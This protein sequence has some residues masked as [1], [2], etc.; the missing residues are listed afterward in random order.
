MLERIINGT[1]L[2]ESISY[3]GGEQ[4][5]TYSGKKGRRV[6]FFLLLFGMKLRRYSVALVRVVGSLF[7]YP[8]VVI[9]GARQD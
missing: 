6:L 1:N 5:C 7:D 3:D 2:Q 8:T 9:P 4:I